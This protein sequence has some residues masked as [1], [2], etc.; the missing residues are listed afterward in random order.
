MGKSL[1]SR[2]E[3]IWWED[4]GRGVQCVMWRGTSVMCAACEWGCD[5]GVGVIWAWGEPEGAYVIWAMWV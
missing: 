2:M 4:G 1:P 3:S 5:M